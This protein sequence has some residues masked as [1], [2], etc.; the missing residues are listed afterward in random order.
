MISFK[1]L[2]RMG[3][4][5]NQLFQIASTISLAIDNG[6]KYIFSPWKYE[7]NFNLYDCFSEQ[8]NYRQQYREPFFHYHP[9]PFS[10]ELDLYGYFQSEKYF[11]NNKEVILGLLTPQDGLSKK[12]DTTSIHIRRGDYLNLTKEYEQLNMDYYQQ[13]M[14]L[15]KSKKYIIISDDIEWCKRQFIG[16]HFEFSHGDEIT[17]LN[18]QISCANNI[19]ANS[20]FSWWGAYLNKNPSKIVVAP[21]K[22][23][24]A[25]L[26]HDTKDLIPKD[27][28]KL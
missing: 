9:I 27:W 10:D 15:I 8:I 12:W 19:I 24:G 6:V 16:D 28:I 20:S 26:P 3:R 1:D 13:A 17:D 25:A 23:F 7:N 5:G 21:Q 11:E 22:W 18:I 14:D 4:F 2:G